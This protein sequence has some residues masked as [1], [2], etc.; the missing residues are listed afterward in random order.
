MLKLNVDV[1]WLR[2]P[3]DGSASGLP[4]QRASGFIL[5]T[6]CLDVKAFG[7]GPQYLRII[8]I[9]IV[10]IHKVE[11]VIPKLSMVVTFAPINVT[12][13]VC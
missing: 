11:T 9:H 7:P 6:T 12:S 2:S 13:E 1:P 10:P 5:P 3:K 8:D 4:L